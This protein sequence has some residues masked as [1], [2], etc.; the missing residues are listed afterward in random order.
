MLQGGRIKS[1]AS[2]VARPV[3][4]GQAIRSEAAN[5]L[6]LLNAPR[7]V[8]LELI[9]TEACNLGCTYCFEY[10]ANAKKKMTDSTAKKAVDFLLESSRQSRWVGIALMGGE[11][12]L[13]FDLIKEIADY[14]RLKARESGKEV[15]FDMQ[16]N[17]V[18]ISRQHAEYFRDIRLRYCLSLDGAQQTNDQYRRSLGGD[19]TFQVVAAKLKMLKRFQH[20]QGARMTIMPQHAAAL[21]DNIAHLHEEL[22][23]NQFVIGFAT[24]VD[25][26]DSQIA[27]YARGLKEA[28]D[29]YLTHRVFQKSRRLRIGLFEFGDLSEAYTAKRKTNWGCGAGSGRLAVGAD[30]VYHG[31]SKLAWGK[32][33]GSANAPL[34]LGNVQTGISTPGNRLKL[35]DRSEESR[36]KCT[37]CEIKDSCQGGCYAANLAD[38]GDMYTPAD[39]FCKLIF[40]QKAAA[41]Y[42][43]ERLRELG[44]SDLRWNSS[45]PDLQNP[46]FTVR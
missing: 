12:M 24:H 34:P 44:I 32:N 19:G 16:T 36:S 45:V 5:T 21:R 26:E 43:R 25:W 15:E 39:Y 11:P 1:V 22:A 29:Y 14:A 41:D 42:A 27:D 3:S 46:R 37:S 13:Q 23:I 17:G 6:A 33:G 28:F 20:W 9:L 18:L 4:G 30:G 2:N 40:A 10:G 8:K 7:I 31:C 35:L 38:T